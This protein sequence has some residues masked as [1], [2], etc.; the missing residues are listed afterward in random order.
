MSPD[1]R[2]V[3]VIVTASLLL[4][5]IAALGAAMRSPRWTWVL[6]ICLAALALTWVGIPRLDARGRSVNWL[7]AIAVLNLLFVTPEL[8]LRAIDFRFES[9]IQ[10]GYPRPEKFVHFEADEELFWK[11]R[12]SNPEANSMGLP[13][14][15]IEVPKPPGVFRIV[16]LGD[17]VTQQGYPEGVEQRLNAAAA[18]EGARVEAAMLA[19]S[20]YSSHQGLVLARK[21][22]VE[23]EP[24]LAVVFFG[25]NDHWKAYGAVDADKQVRVS[26]S[27]GGRAGSW[28]LERSRG[29]QS[30]RWARSK[31]RA[32]EEQQIDDVR[33]PAD[34][35]R[36][37]LTEIVR[38]FADL[39]TP[40]VLITAPSAHQRLG[41]PDY[42]VEKRF[43]ADKPTVIA[44]HQAYNDIVRDVARDQGGLLLDLAA[45][46]DTVPTAE[47]GKL[48]QS[49]GIHLEP[50]GLALVA[51][52]VAEF[53]QGLLID[54]RDGAP[55]AGAGG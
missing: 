23:L 40:T 17:S 30:L 15:E 4:S 3:R 21:Y 48:F 47:L 2:F 22:G 20:G 38:T 31:L 18:I 16:F 1:A 26:Q 7:L 14:D 44:L 37:N 13:G 46:V 28:T 49:D 19:L 43:A 50:D 11:L 42:L 12:A 39:G 29:L 53:I 8:A 41:V 5:A 34:S 10:F 33:V 36:R 9:G 6:L 54:E 52:E 27:L 24:D 35:Y 45:E 55:V 32:E 51:D 25:W